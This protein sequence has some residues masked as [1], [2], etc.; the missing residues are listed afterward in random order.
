MSNTNELIV[1]S[2]IAA[3]AVN[4][5]TPRQVLGLLGVMEFGYHLMDNMV[6]IASMDKPQKPYNHQDTYEFG[7][8]D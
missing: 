2:A 1:L 7:E 4:S 6:A 5:F 3:I 8:E